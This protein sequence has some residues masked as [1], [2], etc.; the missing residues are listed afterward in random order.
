[1]QSGGDGVAKGAVVIRR[2]ILDRLATL[3][4]RAAV[5]KGNARGLKSRNRSIKAQ[6]KRDLVLNNALPR[7]EVNADTYEVRA[8]GE[9]LRSDPA[10][11]LPLAQ[12]YFLF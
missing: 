4:R 1:M 8:D 9:V 10:D 2:L 7:I 3:I 12:R 6:A 5:F 11:V